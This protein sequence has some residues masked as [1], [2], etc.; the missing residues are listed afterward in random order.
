[1]FAFAKLIVLGSR[2]LL[3]S[4]EACLPRPTILV[5]REVGI[6]YLKDLIEIPAPIVAISRLIGG[7]DIPRFLPLLNSPLTLLFFEVSFKFS[8]MLVK[9]IFI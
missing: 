4:S 3:P 1:M 6:C 7:W 2:W 9:L 5:R 8:I